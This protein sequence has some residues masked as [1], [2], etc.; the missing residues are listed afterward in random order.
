MESHRSPEIDLG[1]AIIL[2]LLAS[3][4]IEFAS[5]VNWY[6]GGD[7]VSYTGTWIFHILWGGA[8]L[9]GVI[10]LYR[11]LKVHLWRLSA[12]LFVG[13][14]ISTVG[15]VLLPDISLVLNANYLGVESGDMLTQYETSTGFGEGFKRNYSSHLGYLYHVDSP[16]FK[17]DFESKKQSNAY[18]GAVGFLAW[19]S[20]L[21]LGFTPD[22]VSVPQYRSGGFDYLDKLYLVA[23]VGPIA[24]LELFIRGAARHFLIL[25][26]AQLIFVL[27]KERHV[28]WQT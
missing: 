3:F 5:M 10:W 18:V 20:G 9:V 26:L 12:I 6:V 25:L 7:H 28:W 19:Q 8:A 15:R 14:V 27:I 2:T 22:P 1:K 13:Y 16:D 4:L 21:A 11:K 17:K 23:S 24:I